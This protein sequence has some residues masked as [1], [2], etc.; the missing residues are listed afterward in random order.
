M[1]V[2]L[3]LETEEQSRAQVVA[4]LTALDALSLALDAHGHEWTDQER[5]LVRNAWK[6]QKPASPAPPT[7]APYET[8]A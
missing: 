1:D 2:T 3:T 4:A 7:L 6:A 8:P 5:R